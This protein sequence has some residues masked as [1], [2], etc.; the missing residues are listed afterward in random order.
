MEFWALEPNINE[1]SRSVQLSIRVAYGASRLAIFANSGKSALHVVSMLSSIFLCHAI[2]QAILCK[3]GQCMT[4]VQVKVLA[5]G[6]RPL[7]ESPLQHSDGYLHSITSC[8]MMQ[9]SRTFLLLPALPTTAAQRMSPL[10][11]G[12]PWVIHLWL[13]D[14]CTSHSRGKRHT[15]RHA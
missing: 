3:A 4:V 12:D 6:W 2:L 14:S 13:A 1:I 11:G 7:S 5:Y 15:Y 8:N 9:H 10:G